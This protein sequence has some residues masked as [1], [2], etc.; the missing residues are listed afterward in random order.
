MEL[1]E[2]LSGMSVDVEF[3][4]FDDIKESGVPQDI[5][6]I[7][8]AGDAGTAFSGGDKWLDKEIITNIKRMDI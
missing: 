5:D 8:N 1:L 7:I 6:V 4:S 2:S 3:I